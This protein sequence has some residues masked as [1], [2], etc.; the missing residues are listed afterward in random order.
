MTTIRHDAGLAVL[1]RSAGQARP[2]SVRDLLTM[3]GAAQVGLVRVERLS[4]RMDEARVPLAEVGTDALIRASRGPRSRT[5]VGQLIADDETIAGR[6]RRMDNDFNAM[7]TAVYGSARALPTNPTPAGVALGAP[8]RSSFLTTVEQWRNFR[9][10]WRTAGALETATRSGTVI[11]NRLDGFGADLARFAL[12]V[13]RVSGGVSPI[14]SPEPAWSLPITLDTGAARAAEA[15]GGVA[16]AIAVTA[17]I[18][19]VGLIV[20][21]GSSVAKKVI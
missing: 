3:A 5:G 18:L 14:A 2:A 8:W 1:L 15:V 21:E 12:D 17:G 4:E 20:Y 13:S 9:D 10:D 19:V 16:T 7:L 11:V 6:F